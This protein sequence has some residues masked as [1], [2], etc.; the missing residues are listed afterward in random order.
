MKEV[1]NKSN[2]VNIAN[3]DNQNSEM[4]LIPYSDDFKLLDNTMYYP[5]N[6]KIGTKRFDKADN[7]TDTSD[8]Q[9]YIRKLIIERGKKLIIPGTLLDYN[10]YPILISTKYIH[11]G[12]AKEVV[13]M[14]YVSFYAMQS[15]HQTIDINLKNIEY[16]KNMDNKINSAEFLMSV[17]YRNF[18]ALFDINK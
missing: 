14:Y 6:G 11:N 15:D 9:E 18:R 17:F 8:I 7:H 5:L 4:Y 2:L 1:E 3:F 10:G 13:A 16:I 12:K